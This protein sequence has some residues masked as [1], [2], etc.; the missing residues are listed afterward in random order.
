MARSG[1]SSYSSNSLTNQ[2]NGGILGSGI[3]GNFGSFVNCDAEDSS[4]YCNFIKFFNVF[5]ALFFIGLVLY[6]LYFFFVKRK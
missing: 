5:M 1:K 2:S 3:F 6:F 4:L